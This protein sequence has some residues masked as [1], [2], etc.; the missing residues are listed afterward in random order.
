MGLDVMKIIFLVI[1]LESLAITSWMMVIWFSRNRK[2][3]LAGVST[4]ES[5][6]SN[7]ITPSDSATRLKAAHWL[8]INGWQVEAQADDRRPMLGSSKSGRRSITRHTHQ[9]RY[10]EWSKERHD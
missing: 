1:A 5:S 6:P 3:N 4:D 10:K 9:L 2:L 8:F 7:L